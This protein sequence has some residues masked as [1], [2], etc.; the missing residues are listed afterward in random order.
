MIEMMLPPR[1]GYGMLINTADTFAIIPN[2]RYMSPTATNTRRLATCKYTVHLMSFK[3]NQANAFINLTYKC[4]QTI[5]TTENYKLQT[6]HL[7][8]A[9][10]TKKK[11]TFEAQWLAR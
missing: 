10:F 4:P 7:K 1:T 8:N 6:Q 9:T 5:Q 11:A 3:H 2:T